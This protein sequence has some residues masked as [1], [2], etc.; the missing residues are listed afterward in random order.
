MNNVTINHQPE[1][2][3]ITLDTTT[4]EHSVLADKFANSRGQNVP[5][6]INFNCVD[7]SAIEIDTAL[8]LN[9]Y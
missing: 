6:K 3:T 2:L 4:E 5:L 1:A 8:E 9:F 7:G